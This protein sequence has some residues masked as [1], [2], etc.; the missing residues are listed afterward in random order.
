MKYFPNTDEDYELWV[1]L[2]Q[3]KD[4]VEIARD[5]ELRSYGISTMQAAV[6]FIVQ[7]IGNKATP[8][9]ISRWIFRKHHSVS[10]ILNRMEKAG[11]VSR[12]RDLDK[13]NLVRVALTEKGQQ[14]YRDSLKRESLHNIIAS[15]SKEKRQQI[16]LC[17]KELR[18]TALKQV[19]NEFKL[20]FP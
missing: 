9:E 7:A 20:P 5:K 2:Y 19:G 6:L 15:L 12:V 4:A 13:K 17:L 1:L 11:L 14:A 8:A 16:R 3:A 10:G 18:D